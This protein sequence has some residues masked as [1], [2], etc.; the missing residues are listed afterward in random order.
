LLTFRKDFSKFRT[1]A[2][3]N[4]HTNLFAIAYLQGIWII[5]IET[6]SAA[7]KHTKQLFAK[8]EQKCQNPKVI[9]HAGVATV[10]D[11]KRRQNHTF[12]RKSSKSHVHSCEWKCNF[13]DF[14]DDLTYLMTVDGQEEAQKGPCCDR[15]LMLVFAKQLG[16]ALKG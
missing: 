10:R 2:A 16:K 12:T 7:K 1:R 8:M 6:F 9:L 4:E 14:C 5:S 15:N 11:G 13:D 3:K